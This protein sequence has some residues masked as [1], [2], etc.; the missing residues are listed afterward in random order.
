MGGLGTRVPLAEAQTRA[1]ALLELLGPACARLEVV[2]SVRRR[3]ADVGDLELLAIP[4]Y[5]ERPKPGAL[6][7]LQ[8]QSELAAL[9][10]ELLRSE[11][12]QPRLETNG[13]TRLGSRYSALV[14]DG[15]PLDLFSVLAPTCLGC[16]LVEPRALGAGWPGPCQACAGEDWRVPQWGLLQVIRTG[17]NEFSKHLVTQR[18]KGGWLPDGLQV[19]DGAIWRQAGLLPTW[20]EQ[21]VFEALGL[22]FLRPEQRTAT[23]WPR[24]ER[25]GLIWRE[26]QR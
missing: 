18:A 13:H 3:Q 6:W 17:P 1:T 23:S 21:D 2:G 5:V 20:D 14:F 9:Q 24:A 15:L 12:V 10:T 19:R 25:T 22:P 4:R 8:W 7:D 26:T 11:R 16:D